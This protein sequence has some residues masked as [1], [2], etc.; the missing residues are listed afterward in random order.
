MGTC[1]NGYGFGG[2]GKKS[3][4]RQF[5]DFGEPF[6]KGDCIGCY[7]DLD[8]QEIYF[9]KNGVDLGLAFTIPKSQSQKTFF[10]AIVLKVS[11]SKVKRWFSNNV[12]SF[13]KEC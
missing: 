12:Y 10:P 7:I 11:S 1:P 13:F 6:G 5:D 9:T 4:N 3:N 8:N 2:T